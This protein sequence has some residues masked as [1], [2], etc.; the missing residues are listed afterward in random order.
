ME[1]LITCHSKNTKFYSVDLSKNDAV[2]ILHQ[3][4]HANGYFAYKIYLGGHMVLTPE[5]L[6]TKWAERSILKG[7]SIDMVPCYTTMK[8]SKLPKPTGNRE[9]GIEEG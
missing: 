7:D 3:L 8:F 5:S 2:T 1:N 9:H 4:A 6:V